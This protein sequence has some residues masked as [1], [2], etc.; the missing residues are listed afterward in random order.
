MIPVV[1]LRCRTT[2][3]TSPIVTVALLA[4]PVPVIVNLPPPRTPDSL[5]DN[6][7]IERGAA[8]PV[9]VNTTVCGLPV[10]LSVKTRLAVRDPVEVGVNLKLTV[11]VLVAAIDRLEQLSATI[12]KSEELDPLKTTALLP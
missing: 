2:A 8:T 12:A 4:K 9:P 6:L 1:P 10:A 5:S 3:K 7:E 11:Q